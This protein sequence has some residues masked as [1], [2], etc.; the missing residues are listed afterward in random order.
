[1]NTLEQVECEQRLDK[2]FSPVYWRQTRE[3]FEKQRDPTKARFVHY[4]SA[5]AALK[6]IQNKRIWMRNVTAMTDYS[7]VRHGYGILVKLF[8]TNSNRKDF[9]EALDTCSPGAAAEAFKWFDNWWNDIN[10]NTYIT[11]VSEHD[12]S[13]DR[14]GRLSM[15][16]AFGG[17][18]VRVALVIA[19]PESLL[20]AGVLNLVFS[21]VAY[22]T[23]QQ[24]EE[25]FIQIGKNVRDN[26]EF[27]KSLEGPRIRQAVF[28]TLVAAVTCLKHEGFK[29]ERE[30][31][32]IYGPRR[33]KSE[34]I[35][36]STEVVR[37]IPQVVY[38]IP[39]DAKVSPTLAEFDLANL[40]EHL[41]IGPA[42]VPWSM[43]EAFHVALENAGVPEP[44][45]RIVI[46]GIPVR[47]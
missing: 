31:R 29:E 4:T 18:T 35:D 40:F 25:Q 36:S 16:R 42:Q 33:W 9:I 1:M 41:I 28:N 5:D 21:P 11:S 32:L 46:S 24:V 14:H 2:I 44:Q 37:G 45:K 27:L 13:E 8:Q 20:N 34:F 26:T 43:L 12:E 6:I 19:I 38:R 3:F 39:L 7:E 17:Q 23:E 47:A 22:L 10:L 30:W 15:W